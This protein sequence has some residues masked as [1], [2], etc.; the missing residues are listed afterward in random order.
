MASLKV[1]LPTVMMLVIL[2]ILYLKKNY[3]SQIENVVHHR[4]IK[5]I[6]KTQKPYIESYHKSLPKP[7]PKLTEEDTFLR[8]K[9]LCGDLC[10][11]N[12]EVI[13]GDFMG[14]VKADVS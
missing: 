5:M 10:D 3:K 13:L 9:S 4:K 14:H 7:A 6:G 11:V 12:K 2:S 8:I 1:L